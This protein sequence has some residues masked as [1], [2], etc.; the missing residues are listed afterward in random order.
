MITQLYNFAPGSYVV[1]DEWNGNFSALYKTNVAHEEVIQDC[2]DICAFPN[3]DLTGVFD[4]VKEM[5]NSHLIEG[6]EVTLSAGQ[7][8]YKTLPT[9]KNLLIIYP[10][11]FYG[12]AR[13]LVK[14]EEERTGFQNRFFNMQGDAN[15]SMNIG[16]GTHWHFNPGFYYFVI[17]STRRENHHQTYMK[18]L[19]TGA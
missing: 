18:L 4:A 11:D 16:I 8:Y 1:A 5:P 15:A 17:F 2:Y 6:L 9:G 14:L 13:I 19:Y 12:E 3:S 10:E 7:E